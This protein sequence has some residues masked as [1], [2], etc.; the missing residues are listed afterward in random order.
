VGAEK[1]VTQARKMG[2]VKSFRTQGNGGCSAG[3]YGP[4]IATGGVDITLEEMVF[5]YSVF[6]NGGMMR[7][8]T[9]FSKH[10]T[11]ERNLDPIAILKVEDAQKRMR[12]DVAQRRGEERIVKPEY[13]YLISNILSDASAQ[14]ITFG[15]GGI[16]V[17]GRQAAVKTGTSE[18]F[19][20]KGPF[21]GMIGE[22]WTF[23]YTPDIVVGIWAGNSDNEPIRPNIF[24]TSIAFRAMRD[25]MQ[26]WYNGRASTAFE[27][28][29]GVVE[30]TVCVPSGMKPSA[31]CGRTT[32]DIFAKDSVPKEE[33]TWW[34]RVR[35]DGRTGL[36]ASPT[37][38]SQFVQEQLMLAVPKDLMEDE[39]ARKQWQEWAG[40][41]G[42]P[43]APT[44]FSPAV[45]GGGPTSDLPAAIFSPLPG[46]TLSGQVTISG[47]A[48][49]ANFIGYLLEYG[50]GVSPANWR[51]IAQS[52]SQVA[53][54][55]LG[56][57][58]TDGLD[59]GLYTL[60]LTVVDNRGQRVVASVTVNVGV[61]APTPVPTAQPQSP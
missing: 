1:I 36:L 11:G 10:G 26:T 42:I 3:S 57:W 17:P 15:C 29:E 23:G 35:I 8:M 34:Q 27:R 2:F 25:T 51:P 16:T 18:P 30:E 22:T 4:A 45:S 20:P 59:P 41:L 54:G 46:Q 21:A 39:D 53:A 60:R 55:P 13:T 52:A 32:R 49:T 58:N 19:D 61:A 50:E 31:A 56:V 5:G 28:P 43:L 14:C 7:G 12:F 40:A 38:P 37:T 6:A 44:D 48:A 33:D 47:R 24:S 9:P